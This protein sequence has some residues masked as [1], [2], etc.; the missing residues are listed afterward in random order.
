MDIQKDKT[1]SGY[2][3]VLKK[4][5][6]IMKRRNVIKRLSMLPIASVFSGSAFPSNGQFNEEVN[7]KREKRDLYKELNVQDQI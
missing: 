2:L 1:N 5:I 3:E 6:N 4:E 7:A